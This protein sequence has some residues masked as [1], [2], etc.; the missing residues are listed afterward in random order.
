M[1]NDTP[2]M[3]NVKRSLPWWDFA[4]CS[5]PLEMI[6]ELILMD[7]HF[8]RQTHALAVD[9]GLKWALF[10]SAASGVWSIRS[11]ASEASRIVSHRLISL[12]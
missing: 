5:T 3:S 10:V 2:Q 9:R 7:H 11:T 8:D 4:F 1:T 6:D 12:C